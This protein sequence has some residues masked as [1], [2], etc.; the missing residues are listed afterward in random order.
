[1]CA[2]GYF[3]EQAGLMTTG[4]SLVRENAASLEPPRTLWVSFP[5]GRP[6]GVPNDASFQHR[7]I[8]AA[9]DLLDHAEGPVLADYPEDAP[10]VDTDASPA[11]PVSFGTDATTWQVRLSA[12]LANLSPWYQIGRDRR[13]GRTMVG[14]SASSTEEIIERMAADLD[15][16]TLPDNLSW[17]K[18]AIEDVKAYYVEALTAQPGAYDPQETYNTLWHETELG[19]A[20][21]WFY[22]RFSAHPQLSGFARIVLPRDATEGFNPSGTTEDTSL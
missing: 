14:V 10:R 16:E 22:D 1:M 5:L 8:S 7:V 15:A 2:L 9:L 17:F 18:A 21:R 13:G 3:L 6:L 19:A 11:C 12:E 4:I 20:L